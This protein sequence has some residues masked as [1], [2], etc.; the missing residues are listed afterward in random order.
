MRTVGK[1]LKVRVI[2]AARAT[3]GYSAYKLIKP[4]RVR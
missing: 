1:P 2:W 3:P 4:Y